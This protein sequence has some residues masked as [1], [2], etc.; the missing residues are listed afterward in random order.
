MGLL[1]DSF[2]IVVIV[3]IIGR[4][5]AWHLCFSLGFPPH[6]GREDNFWIKI[7]AIGHFDRRLR[8]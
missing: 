4:A 6:V 8:K 7:A 2:I 5:P 1:I 3:Q